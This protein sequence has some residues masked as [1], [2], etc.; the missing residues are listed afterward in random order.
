M[1]RELIDSVPFEMSA[2]VPLQLG[3]ESIS[4]S[5]TAISELIKNSYDA[6][7][8]EVKLSFYGL[9]KPVSTLLLEDNGFGMN[10]E[11]LTKSWLR[12]GTENKH[13]VG[14]SLKGRVL[15]GAKGLGRLGIDRLCKKMV[16]YTKTK[17]M[18]HVLQLNI[19]WKKFEN[20][21][22]SLSEIKHSIFKN[23]YPM[24]DRFGTLFPDGEG[25]RL[26]LI[27]LKDDW[28]GYI[29]DDLKKELRLLVSPF[30]DMVDFSIGLSMDGKVFDALNSSDI[31]ESAR[32]TINAEIENNNNVSGDF[33]YKPDDSH[34]SFRDIKWGEWIKSRGDLP[35][36]GPMKFQLYFIPRENSS[37]EKVDFNLREIRAF[38]DANQGVRI[39]RDN[40]RVRPYGEPSGKGDWLDLG[41]RKVRSPQGIT[42]GGW[43]VGP[44]QVVGAVFI[45]REINAELDDQANREGIVENDAFFDM[46]AFIIKV[47]ETFESIATKKSR[48]TD[49]EDS[50]K[51]MLEYFK[52]ENEKTTEIAN[53]LKN[54]ISKQSKKKRVNKKELK[55]LVNDFIS[56]V[57]SQNE[58]T[59]KVEKLIETLEYQKDTMANLASIGIL[60]V[61]LGH[62]SKQHAGLAS[63]RA[64]LLKRSISGHEEEIKKLGIDSISEDLDVIMSS[65]KYITSFAKFALSNV[66]PDKRER[67]KIDLKGIIN[68]VVEVFSPSLEKSEINLELNIDQSSS[69][70]IRGYEIDWESTVINL[71]TNSIWALEGKVEGERVIKI[72]L[73]GDDNSVYLNF[74]DSGCGLESG[75]ESQI[76]DIN[77][78]TRKDGKGNK[79]GTGMGLPI[80]KTFVEEH[81]GGSISVIANGEKGG[82][83]FVIRVP[84]Y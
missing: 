78:S 37:A 83:E 47:I 66:R 43:K 32:W 28:N 54:T 22:L 82:A 7:A 58:N 39:Y 62:E 80:V 19:D 56:V 53:K 17:E 41:L 5:T 84:R 38:L 61:C 33:H 65:V 10:L 81:S 71:L 76:F 57:D 60:T 68:S 31:L 13:I 79:I 49:K 55:S 63:N 77:F 75:T 52:K 15:T 21:N 12:I 35:K 11:A 69:F 16:L 2:R 27:G 74:C 51:I 25:T 4:N 46:R 34:F 9:G 50:A 29:L 24:S 3:R 36:C 45:S 8:L 6:D 20:T 1:T 30:S 14:R 73:M 23:S 18:D 72:S 44:N 64:F 42:Q 70:G 40:F 48:G 67:K 26:L 59:R